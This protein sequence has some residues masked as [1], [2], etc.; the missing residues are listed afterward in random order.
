MEK[1]QFKATINAPRNTVWHALWADNYYRHWTSVFYEG[2]YAESNWNEGDEIKFLG[3]GGGG[4]YSII[5][6]KEEPSL[7]RFKHLGELKNNEKQP[8]SPWSGAIEEYRLI[9][10]GNQTELIT[11]IDLTDEMKD[12]F[13]KTF[14]SALEKI[15]A[16]AES[17]EIKSVTI[18][19]TVN[20]PVE[21]V[22]ESWTSPGH[23][24]KW[25]QASPDWH[26]PKAEN[27]VKP[28]GQFSITM[29]AKD[30]S[31]SFD[32]GGTYD[33]VKTNKLIAYTIGDGRKVKVNFEQDGNGTKVVEKFETENTNPVA[34]Q[35][36]GW[37]SI[38]NSFKQYTESLN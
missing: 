9:E 24:T 12:Y 6:K 7:M 22:W 29:A 5:D 10:N 34:M 23:I 31:F 15:K 36:M 14:P 3:P 26:C 13:M 4:M 8:A 30:G 16:I 27:D 35:Q 19:A 20:A 33:E 18:E 25:N 2:S 17:E 32:F 11:E 21:K 38:L 1:Q 37:Q 28:G